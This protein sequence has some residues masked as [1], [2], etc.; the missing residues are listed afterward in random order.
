MRGNMGEFKVI[1]NRIDVDKMEV[2]LVIHGSQVACKVLQVISTD[3]QL[4]YER[5]FEACRDI[6]EKGTK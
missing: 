3:S 4:I 2:A 5:C 1:A 6:I